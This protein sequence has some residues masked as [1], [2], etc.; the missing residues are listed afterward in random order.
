MVF[1]ECKSGTANVNMDSQWSKQEVILYVRLRCGSL[2]ITAPVSHL[3]N[4]FYV[5]S[6]LHGQASL[7]DVNQIVCC[8]WGYE[9]LQKFKDSLKACILY[10]QTSLN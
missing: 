10:I 4:E 7:A 1:L 6:E 8:S 2:S 9:R 5:R 3:V